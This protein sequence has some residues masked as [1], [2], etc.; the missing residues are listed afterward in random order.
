MS[1]D[2]V[3]SS[4]CTQSFYGYYQ[5]IAKKVKERKVDL[6][7]LVKMFLTGFDSKTLNTLWVDKNPKHHGLIQA[8]SSTNRILRELMLL[9][10]ILKSF[11]AFDD[12]D[13]SLPA[14]RLPTAAVPNW[15]STTR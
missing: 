5:D 1:F 10:N 4:K 15:T 6:L 13:L 8:Y 11:Y 9:P 2:A 14:Q 12:N 7:L 3:F